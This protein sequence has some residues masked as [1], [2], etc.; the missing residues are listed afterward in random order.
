MGNKTG[1]SL[2]NLHVVAEAHYHGP[3][4]VIVVEVVVVVVAERYV[5]ED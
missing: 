1:N 4:V 2:G 3:L 5:H